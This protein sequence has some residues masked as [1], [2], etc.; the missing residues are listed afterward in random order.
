M[1]RLIFLMESGRDTFVFKFNLIF[2]FILPASTSLLKSQETVWSLVTSY[3]CDRLVFQKAARYVLKSQR[4][5]R[6][7]PLNS[8]IQLLIWWFYIF[9]FKVHFLYLYK[10][11]VSKLKV[12]F[13]KIQIIEQCNHLIKQFCLNDIR[14]R[15][16]V[17][18]NPYQI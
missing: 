4:T 14:I 7:Y 15:S 16:L 8:F 5:P 6:N 18:R 10:N 11:K 13:D 17:S 12:T 3:Q 9:L 1:R 2:C